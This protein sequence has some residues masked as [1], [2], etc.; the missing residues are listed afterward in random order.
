MRFTPSTQMQTGD[1]C[2]EATATAGVI[3]GS[4]TSGS[5]TWA[6]YEFG[7]GSDNLTTE[8]Y[9]FEITKGYTNRARIIVIG[10]G[11]GGGWD[12]TGTYGTG[13]G[14]GAGGVVINNN[15]VLSPNIYSIKKGK[16]GDSADADH[17]TNPT[18]NGGSGVFSEVNGGIYVLANVIKAEGGEGGFGTGTNDGDGGESGNGFA[19]GQDNARGTAG[20]GGATGVGGDA[21]QSGGGNDQ[22]GNGGPGITIDIG[23]H[24]PVIGDESIGGDP[25]NTISVGGGGGG[26]STNEGIATDGGGNGGRTTGVGESGERHHGGGGGGAAANAASPPNQIGTQGGDGYVI[27]LF[28]TGSCP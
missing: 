24:S 11:G 14:G 28:P 3:S 27:I 19:G 1:L 25:L 16:G 20:G 22:G 13:G 7:S 23:Y 8:D 26:V 15:A 18:F 9:Q 4:Y 6:Y 17:P 10:G 21:F 2:I 5:E 12:G